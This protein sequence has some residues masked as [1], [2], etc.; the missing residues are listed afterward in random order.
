MRFANRRGNP[1]RKGMGRTGRDDHNLRRDDNECLNERGGSVYGGPGEFGTPG[2]IGGGF[3]G[4]GVTAAGRGQAA[5]VRGPEMS[6]SGG[7]A[8]LW[9]PSSVSQ[10]GQCLLGGRRRGEA[11]PRD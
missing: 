9:E 10:W 2:S 8:P 3:E 4:A 11:V 5:I 6:L 7:T 1:G